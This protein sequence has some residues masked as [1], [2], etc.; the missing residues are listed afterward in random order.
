MVQEHLITFGPLRLETTQA[1]LWR[2]EQAVP[3]RRHTFAMLR[4]LAE[5][6]GRLVTK[7]ELRQH[8]WQG[9]HVTDTVLRGCNRV[10][11]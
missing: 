5:H 11:A 1:R 9:T 3:L 4:Y 7:A 6:P 8:V 10:P 2:G